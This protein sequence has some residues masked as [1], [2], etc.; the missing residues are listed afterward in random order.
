MN[1]RTRIAVQM[2]PKDPM[3]HF[4]SF[5]LHN[6]LTPVT[7]KREGFE[8]TSLLSIPQTNSFVQQ[9]VRT[10]DIYEQII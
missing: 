10:I 5:F 8:K 7:P 6:K 3:A 1:L 9:K 2:N 4:L